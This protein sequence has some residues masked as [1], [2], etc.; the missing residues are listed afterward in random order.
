MTMLNKAVGI[1][2]T[3]SYV[4][5]KVLTNA[6]LEKMVDTSDAWIQERTGI[7]E[8]RIAPEGVNASDMATEAAK[9]ALEA[10]N[11]TAEDLDCIIVAT[12]TGDMAIPS[13]A[14]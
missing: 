12:L 3:G 14:C 13:T 7:K 9:K 8:R 10:A 4:P 11:L 1:I 5:E 2:G 6:D